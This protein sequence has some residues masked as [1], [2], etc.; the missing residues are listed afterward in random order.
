MYHH[1]SRFSRS[2]RTNSAEAASPTRR[3]VL[4]VVFSSV[5]SIRTGVGAA[6]ESVP[7]LSHVKSPPPL[8]NSPGRSMLNRMESPRVSASPP[9]AARIRSRSPSLKAIVSS[10]S[11]IAA[12]GSTSPTSSQ[13]CSANSARRRNSKPSKTPGP[14]ISA[15][16]DGSS[17]ALPNGF[18]ARSHSRLS[19]SRAGPLTSQPASARS[20]RSIR[21]A[22]SPS[23]SAAA[24]SRL[25][26]TATV[27]EPFSATS[28]STP[29]PT[30]QADASSRAPARV[31]TSTYRRR[32]RS[33]RRARSGE[34]RVCR[35]PALPADLCR[36]RTVSERPSPRQRA[37]G[38]RTPRRP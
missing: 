15:R 10:S 30:S 19:A 38:A 37:V 25:T 36:S 32:V 18:V 5:A 9:T 29:T 22:R 20:S 27:P 7:R 2:A 12:A 28:M 6:G 21:L 11:G 35:P 26:P 31:A 24:R 33:P 16:I 4:A 8:R 34:G 13:V 23:A 14:A 3:S 17:S 1:P